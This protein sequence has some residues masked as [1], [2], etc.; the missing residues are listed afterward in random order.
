[1]AAETD[2]GRLL[3]QAHRVLASELREGMT[4]RGY[5]DVRPGHS[6]AFM[7]IDRRSGTRLRMASMA[8]SPSASTRTPPLVRPA[9]P[10]DLHQEDQA[11]R[12]QVRDD[13]PRVVA[14]KR[15]APHVRIVTYLGNR[16]N[17]ASG[18]E[19]FLE[20]TTEIVDGRRG[21]NM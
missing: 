11:G 21:R 1:M 13:A 17:S 18:F 4:E 3:L 2:L 14:K 15:I 8:R 19:T 10:A 9:S 12:R 6:A 20:T 16:L 5:P 7:H